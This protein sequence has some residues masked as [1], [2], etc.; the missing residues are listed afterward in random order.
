MQ[1]TPTELKLLKEAAI[2]EYKL[3]QEAA[4]ERKKFMFATFVH[5]LR[6]ALP[7]NISVGLAAA[8][9]LVYVNGLKSLAA[10]LLSGIIWLT[11][12]STVLSTFLKENSK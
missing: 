1:L 7:F 2:A 8:G 5:R 9:I 12:V 10:L 3:K 4:S 11:L 6:K